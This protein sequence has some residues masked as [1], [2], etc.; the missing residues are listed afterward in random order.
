MTKRMSDDE[1]KR[2]FLNPC[3]PVIAYE[4]RRTTWFHSLGSVVG[5]Y[6]IRSVGQLQKLI[7]TGATAP[8]GYTT[9]DYAIDGYPYKGM[10]ERDWERL[11]DERYWEENF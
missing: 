1:A 2:G 4:R 10:S 7:N 8:D 3:K 11:V 9:F 6:G 5:S